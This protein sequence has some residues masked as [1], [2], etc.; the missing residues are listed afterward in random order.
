M[1]LVMEAMKAKE[2]LKLHMAARFV[3]QYL[4]GFM[5]RNRLHHMH[6]AAMKVQAHVRMLWHR[7]FYLKLKSDVMTIQR[8]V[9]I[10]LTRRG[11]VKG[12]LAEYLGEEVNSLGKVREY[13]SY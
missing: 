6:L 13:E 4:R 11:V 10:F 5:V 3:Q 7:Q 8:C 1:P 9:R 12:R 2:N